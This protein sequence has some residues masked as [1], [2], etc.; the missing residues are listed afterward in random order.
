MLLDREHV[1]SYHGYQRRTARRVFSSVVMLCFV[2]YFFGYLQIAKGLVL[3]AL[4]SVLNFTVMAQLLPFQLGVGGRRRI[5][6]SLAF[7]SILL[8]FVLMAIPLFI[9][10]RFSDFNFWA[11]AVGLLAVPIAI[12]TENVVLRKLHRCQV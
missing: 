3:G 5:A 7:L 12:M 1:A 6:T 4:F 2:I 11:V 9:G 8:R 10:L